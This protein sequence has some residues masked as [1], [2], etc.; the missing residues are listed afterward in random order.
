MDL[1]VVDGLGEWTSS[2]SQR[3]WEEIEQ[4]LYRGDWRGYVMWHG[5]AS[6]LPAFIRIKHRMPDEEY[7][8]L[9]G[10][11]WTTSRNIRQNKKVWRE[12]WRSSR[13]KK[14]AAMDE[15]GRMQFD[16]LADTTVVYRGQDRRNTSG[17]SWSLDRDQAIWFATHWHT[18][19]EHWLLTGR[20]KKIDVH[21]AFGGKEREIVA[22]KVRVVSRERLTAPPL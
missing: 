14:E 5:H 2:K 6:Q 8:D 13:L 17:M 22:N 12:C 4:A 16:Q 7:W 11:L 10:Y 20:V 15:D 3:C 18:R 1:N 19:P 21:A 9:L